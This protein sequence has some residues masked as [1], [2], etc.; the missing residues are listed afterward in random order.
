ML[1]VWGEGEG[2]YH[3]DRLRSSTMESF[4]QYRTADSLV[5]FGTT[6]ALTGSDQAHRKA[7]YST[8]Q[9]IVWYGLGWDNRSSI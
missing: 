5:W 6:V 9:L 4:I 8:Y 2:L 1:M 7:L 3:L